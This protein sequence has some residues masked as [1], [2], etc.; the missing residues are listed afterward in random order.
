MEM[1]QKGKTN[2]L[3]LVKQDRFPEGVPAVGPRADTKVVGCLRGGKI[4]KNE[5]VSS[6]FHVARFNEIKTSS[7]CR[8]PKGKTEMTQKG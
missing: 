2:G 1:N 5:R 6:I 3:S 7:L 8:V 4:V